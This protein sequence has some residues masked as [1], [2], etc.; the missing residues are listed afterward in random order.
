[1]DD[2]VELMEERCDGE[3]RDD[4]YLIADDGRD[5]ERVDAEKGEA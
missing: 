4:V 5:A 2:G 1:M 3:E